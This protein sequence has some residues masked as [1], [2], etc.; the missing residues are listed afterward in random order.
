M[1]LFLKGIYVIG[2]PILYWIILDQTISSQK[3]SRRAKATP[4]FAMNRSNIKRIHC[5][6]NQ[7]EEKDSS[8]SFELHKPY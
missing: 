5:L 6:R 7:K 3:L 1:D 8:F 2:N 4:R